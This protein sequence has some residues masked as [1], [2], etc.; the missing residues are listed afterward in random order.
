ME[1]IK[2]KTDRKIQ[3]VRS[4]RG[5][6]YFNEFLQ[7]YFDEKSI[8]HEPTTSYS[9]ESNGKAERLNRTLIERARSIIAELTDINGG[10][11]DEHKKLWAEAVNTAN[12]IRNRVINKGTAAHFGMITP[13]QVLF[14]RKPNISNIRIFGSKVHVLKTPKHKADKFDSK[15]LRGIHVGYDA[16]NAYRIFIPTT[17]ELIISRDVTFTEDLME[18]VTE[19]FINNDDLKDETKADTIDKAVDSTDRSVPSDD[20]HDSEKRSRGHGHVR[21]IEATSSDTSTNTQHEQLSDN[22]VRRS[23]RPKPGPPARYREHTSMAFISEMSTIGDDDV[24][25]SLEEAIKSPKRDDWIQAMESEMDSLKSLGAF[26]VRNPPPGCKLIECKWVFA[27]KRG[28]Y[29][30]IVRYKARLVAKGFSQ[31]NGIDYTEVFSPVVKYEIFRLLLGL[32][33][34]KNYEM[35]QVDIKTAFIRSDLEE[36]IYMRL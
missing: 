5:S 15:T 2:N 11:E 14:G 7:S 36:E 18:N 13:Y 4:D 33:A 35:E 19:I 28:S 12:Y 24:P 32:C 20:N 27:L 23:T 29:G 8:A 31:I 9:P 16:G 22:V 10:D 34:A 30:Q 6:E 3:R 26:D 21:T 17:N 1:F 25:R